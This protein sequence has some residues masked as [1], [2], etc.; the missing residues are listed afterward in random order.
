MGKREA[1]PER[2]GTVKR[3]GAPMCALSFCQTEKKKKK[4]KKEKKKKERK[5]KQNKTK[6]VR[7]EFELAEKKKKKQQKIQNPIIYAYDEIL[8][9]AYSSLPPLCKITEIPFRFL[10]ISSHCFLKIQIL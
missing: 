2:N 10:V 5:K 6:K 9:H 7:V 3:P 8:I 1:E 4:R